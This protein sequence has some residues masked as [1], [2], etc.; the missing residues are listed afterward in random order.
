MS[1][2]AAEDEVVQVVTDLLTDLH[3]GQGLNEPL[4]QRLRE[5]LPGFAETW[6]HRETVP[7]EAAGMLAELHGQ[8]VAQSYAYPE[9]QAETIRELAMDLH[10]QVSRAFFG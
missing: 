2:G 10:E 6:P 8:L 9:L 7:R 4:V 1:S 5:L 3:M